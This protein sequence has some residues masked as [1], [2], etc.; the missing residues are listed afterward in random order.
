[1]TYAEENAP[2]W[3]N[4]WLTRYNITTQAEA[5]LHLYWLDKN[6]ALARTDFMLPTIAYFREHVI[7]T[8]PKGYNPFNQYSNQ[9]IGQRAFDAA[10]NTSV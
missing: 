2:K 1:M 10:N 8:L 4:E 6:C 5:L 7:S 9:P 3:A